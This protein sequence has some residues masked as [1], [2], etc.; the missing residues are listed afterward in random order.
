MR[1]Q[2]FSDVPLLMVICTGNICRSPMAEAVLRDELAKRDIEA[3]VD[4][5]GLEAPVG[6]SPHKFAIQVND[7][8]GIPIATDKKSIAAVS[9]NLKRATLLLVM[10]HQH[11][12]Q[13]MQRYPFASGKTFLLG[14]WSNEEIADP[15]RSPIEDFEQVYKQVEQGCSLWVDHLVQA[16]M[17]SALSHSYS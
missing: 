13:I 10:D 3:E 5:C 1:M 11:R 6:R 7:Q 17:L 15:V 14:H 4:S 12:Y 2:E 16:G 8:Q 9:A